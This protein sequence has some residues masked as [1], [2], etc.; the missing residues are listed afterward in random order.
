M[1]LVALFTYYLNHF[2]LLLP[3]T[4]YTLV[5]TRRKP[6]PHPTVVWDARLFSVIGEQL[7]LGGEVGG[8]A[9][10]EGVLD[11]KI[12]GFDFLSYFLLNYFLIDKITIC[13]R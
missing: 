7:L 10:D 2:L 5:A 6:L 11:L 12:N 1:V 8:G 3:L 13:T 4:Q 9:S